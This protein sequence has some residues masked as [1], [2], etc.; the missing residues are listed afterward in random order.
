MIREVICI[1]AGISMCA[2]LAAID[3]IGDIKKGDDND[4]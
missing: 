4:K 3:Y 1:V 2:I